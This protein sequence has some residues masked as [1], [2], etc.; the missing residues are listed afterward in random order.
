MI[1][2]DLTE[3]IVAWR[4]W[5]V[6]AARNYLL[7]VRF[8]PCRRV[9]PDDPPDHDPDP[10]L[11][12]PK[13]AVWPVRMMMAGSCAYSEPHEVPCTEATW[14]GFDGI[15]IPILRCRC[16][17]YATKSLVINSWLGRINDRFVYG[18][19]ALWGKVVEHTTGY[20]A[21]YA[22]PVSIS[23][24]ALAD[25]YGVSVEHPVEQIDGALVYP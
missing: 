2:P 5:I 16:G 12:V 10:R 13:Y 11:L 14:V 24:R 18:R 3:P 21:Q 6:S 7:A 22:Y 15:K 17:I 8:F 20:R 4:L 19:V 23:D 25:L 1:I 9:S